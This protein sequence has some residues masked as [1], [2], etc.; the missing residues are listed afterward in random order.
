MYFVYMLANKTRKVLYVGVTND[1]VR[2]VYEHKQ[3]MQEGFSK[4]YHV[5]QMV[6]YE[7]FDEV[8]HAIERE[9]QLKTWHRDWKRRLV[10]K[11]NPF[12]KD[13]YKEICF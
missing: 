6:Y 11:Q 3:Q 12:W 13:L 8:A 9:K 7:Q 2:R 10:E 1:L 5:D 4:E